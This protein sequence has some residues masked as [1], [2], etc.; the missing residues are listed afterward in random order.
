MT[1]KQ[2]FALNLKSVYHSPLLAPGTFILDQGLPRTSGAA[3][4]L[5]FLFLLHL[6]LLCF[7]K[8]YFY[9]NLFLC[10]LYAWI[11]SV[12][13]SRITTAF[14]F[15]S[16]L[17]IFYSKLN[18]LKK[19]VVF[20]ILITTFINSQHIYYH[21]SILQSE[22]IENE[23]RLKKRSNKLVSNFYENYFSKENKNL[24]DDSNNFEDINS[25]KKEEKLKLNQ[26]TKDT[27]DDIKS[28]IFFQKPFYCNEEHFININSSGRLCIWIDN[29][30][31]ALKN[32]R[33][34]YFGHGAQADRYNVKYSSRV[35][36]H[37][38]SNTF[39][40][41]L[42]SGGI[43]SVIL[44]LIIY[45]IFFINFLRFFI[46][47]KYKLFNVSSILISCLLINSFILFRGITESSF[48]VFSLDYMLFLITT[49]I[50]FS[51]KDFNY[52]KN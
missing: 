5:F 52:N 9:I 2:S 48:A 4:A 20:L 21:I 1:I 28:I 13:D 17:V 41:V 26:K 31:T 45:I 51:N 6:S 23:I 34:F 15:I 3:R 8:N 10:L 36:E 40:Y 22:K 19:V 33:V 50:I 25:D 12:F 11:I 7:K 47:D 37:S 46:F 35:Q 39:L 29:L 14:F 32:Y 43:I 27:F 38:A 24:L 42:T 49:F 16:L 18:I 30:N 44:V